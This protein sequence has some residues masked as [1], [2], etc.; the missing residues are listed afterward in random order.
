MLELILQ[1]PI[2]TV[3]T[4]VL[5]MTAGVLVWYTAETCWLRRAAQDQLRAAEHQTKAQ[6]DAHTFDAITRVHQLL[7]S[8][9]AI[10]RRR[11]L[12]ENFK[13]DLQEA[14][15]EKPLTTKDFNHALQIQERALPEGMYCPLKNA[16]EVLADFNV[17]GISCRL[18]IEAARRVAEEYE[19]V[20]RKTAPFLLPFVRTQ[21]Q[22][23]GDPMY[24]REYVA[25]VQSFGWLDK[26]GPLAQYADMASHA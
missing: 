22:L 12:Y 15:K 19:P 7:T 26:N 1:K 5:L 6:L 9:D 18:G 20:I 8:T 2:E 11:W 16:E 14:A 13:E 17:L 3:Q 10:L 24:K 21:R 23:R 4:L 25:L